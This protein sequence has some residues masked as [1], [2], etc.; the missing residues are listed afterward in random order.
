MELNYN[1]VR[2]HYKLFR[3]YE[4]QAFRQLFTPL[5]GPGHSIEI[6][7]ALFRK[8][9]Y[10]RGRVLC[11]FWILGFVCRSS[12]K[13]V[14]IP[15]LNRKIA[16]IKF[17]I[18]KLVLPETTIYTDSYASYNFIQHHPNNYQHFKINHSLPGVG[19]FVNPQNSQINTQTIESRWREFRAH[20]PT[21][22]VSMD[23]LENYI[24]DF[25]LR[26]HL[27]LKRERKDNPNAYLEYINAITSAYPPCTTDSA[28]SSGQN[29]EMF[30]HFYMLQG[31]Y[32]LI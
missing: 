10:H 9:K 20:L 7:E 27:G 21:Y 17:F 8:R 28:I 2:S 26:R 16:T 23:S 15:V 6:D 30:E 18:E 24:Y 22:G 31:H 11:T 19:R 25:M 5:G 12:G 3:E 13:T 4:A 32:L 1:T 29:F 14:L